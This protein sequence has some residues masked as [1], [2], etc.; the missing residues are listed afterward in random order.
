[1][2]LV[3]YCKTGMELNFNSINHRPYI[4]R[5]GRTLVKKKQ[6]EDAAKT[7]T[8]AEQ[9]ERAGSEARSRGLQYTQ[10][11][12][13]GITPAQSQRAQQLYR[14]YAGS[15]GALGNSHAAA[16][17]TVDTPTQDY[18][19]RSASIN[20]AQIIKDF[21]NTSIAIGTPEDLSSEVNNR[22]SLI[23][24][25]LAQENPDINLVKSDLMNASRKLDRY[26]SATLNK[27]SKVVENWMAA[28]FLQ[29]IDFKYNENNI[30][31][32]FLVKFPEG[33]TEK[34]QKAEQAPMPEN[35]TEM[36]VSSGVIEQAEPE[37]N[38]AQSTVYIP[39][40]KELKSLFLQSK[41]LAYAKEPEKAIASF[42]KALERA[43]DLGDTE[44]GA[45]IYYEV[46]KIYDDH[47]F[48]PQALKSY[49]KSLENTTD[50]NVKTK[51][52]YLM[53]R[54]YD[55]VNQIKPALDHYYCSVAW[56][57]ESENLAAQ[58]TSLTRMG[59]IYTD[60]YEQDALDYLTAADELAAETDNS[61]VKGY[62]S[63]SLAKA[64][65]KFGE[66][67]EA[68]KSYSKAVKHYADADSPDKVAQN[69]L[70]A[71]EVMLDYNCENKARG[72][73]QK[74]KNYADK[75]GDQDLINQIK[76]KLSSLSE[77]YQP[78]PPSKQQPWAYHITGSAEED[79]I[80]VIAA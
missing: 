61:K 24:A 79:Y 41:K 54:I 69:Y 72:L 22:I 34:I 46:G 29:D 75:T 37:T 76:E 17:S 71:A 5:D 48:Y 42:K 44:T 26:I 56:G 20:I 33:S 65:D 2:R 74:A 14:Q 15:A 68:L 11:I 4:A 10:E 55:D 19:G 30:N 51:A 28:L 8:Q 27:E 59:N 38:Q 9:E 12:S 57:G 53:G 36:E 52:H 23:Q 3:R 70:N 77:S 49:H 32:Q 66:P 21:K 35:V 60:M 78:A 6:D 40:D 13:N 62:V 1:M 7:L 64:Y 73:L 43:E 31:P 16:R 80:P 25:E 50:N 45:K 18:S 58:S 67:Q 39:Q 47:N 63:S